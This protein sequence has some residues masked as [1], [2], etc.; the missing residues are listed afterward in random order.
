[1]ARILILSLAVALVAFLRPAH[2]QA[3][4]SCRFVHGFEVFHDAHAS[5][6]GAC[7]SDEGHAANGD[8]IQYTSNG[9]LVWTKATNAVRFVPKGHGDPFAD[10]FSQSPS[11]EKSSG[12][13]VPNRVY[14][15]GDPER[16]CRAS[17]P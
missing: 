17:L 5:L 13:P 6:I 16:H 4:P 8:G 15:C 10:R 9:Y 11:W 2:A 1:M 7:V 14:R 12:S 3:A